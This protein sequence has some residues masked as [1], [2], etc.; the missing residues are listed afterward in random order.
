MLRECRQMIPALSWRLPDL[1][2]REPIH[3][4][5]TFSYQV[6]NYTGKGFVCIGDAHRF[7]DPI[8]G[9]GVFF[10]DPGRRVRRR[11]DRAM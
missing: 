8:F 5:P 6:M 11:R 2:P 10:R 3:A 9:Y 1:T 4:F 7:T